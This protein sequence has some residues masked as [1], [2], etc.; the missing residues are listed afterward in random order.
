M[1]LEAAQDPTICPRAP[2]CLEF[3]ADSKYVRH[4]WLGATVFTLVKHYLAFTGLALALKAI[5]KTLDRE[6]FSFVTLHPSKVKEP[7]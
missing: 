3:C 6:K 7:C 2:K 5:I 1:L 4:L